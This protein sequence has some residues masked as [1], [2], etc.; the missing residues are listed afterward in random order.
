MHATF[1]QPRYGIGL[2]RSLRRVHVAAACLGLLAFMVGGAV[3]A[4]DYPS[5]PLTIVVTYP[6][7]GGADLMARL[8]AP[9]LSAKFKQPVTVENRPGASGQIGAAHVAKALPDGYTLM[10]DASSFAVNPGLFAKLP[11]DSEK[12]FTIIGVTALFPNVLVAN[13]MHPAKSVKDVVA[14]AKAKPGEVAFASS[15]NGSAQHLAGALFEL[16]AK[17]D[18]LHVPYKG[19][20]PAMIDVMGGQ[21]PFFFANLASSLPHIKSGK[22]SA[23]AVTSS[24]RTPILPDTPTVAEA[25]VAGY[26]VHEWNMLAVP[27]GTPDKVVA[28]LVGALK[29]ALESPDVKE[30]VSALGGEMFTGNQSDSIKFVRDQTAFWSKVVKD[31]NIKAE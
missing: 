20:G 17:V 2:T 16:Q 13:P 3:E 7:G 27:A 26:Q 25:G 24:K 22:L 31:R 5:K 21:V 6:A 23:L 8:I 12:A 14:A 11:Y 10:F 9:K 1:T 15:G 19:G 4:Q 30:R 28:D 18:M 29:Q